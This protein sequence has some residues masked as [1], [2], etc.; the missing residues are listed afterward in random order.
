MRNGGKEPKPKVA[1]GTFHRS[2]YKQELQAAVRI[3]NKKF[4]KQNSLK[5]CFH[6][7]RQGRYTSIIVTL[8]LSMPLNMNKVFLGRTHMYAGQWMDISF[9]GKELD[10]PCPWVLGVEIAEKRKISINC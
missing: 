10:S 7:K 5:Y 4:M 6:I 2:Q 8:I 3:G 9:H 1:F